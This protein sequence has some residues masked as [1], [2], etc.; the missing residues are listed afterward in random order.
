MD[1]LKV[2]KL[3]EDNV[4]NII[5]E[6]IESLKT[7]IHL[8]TFSDLPTLML[9]QPKENLQSS[10]HYMHFPPNKKQIFHY[11]PSARYLLVLGD[12]DMHIHYNKCDLDSNPYNDFTTLTLPAFTLGIVRYEA[13]VWHYFESSKG[14]NKRGIV[15]FTFHDQDD[16]EEIHDNLM[17]ELTFFYKS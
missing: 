2:C 3:S 8:T 11:H 12:V 16:I 1:F 14:E 15:A 13:N 4:S 9:L 10:F 6:I 7:N 17:E 5:Q